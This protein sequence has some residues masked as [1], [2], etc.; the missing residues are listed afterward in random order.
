M[1]SPGAI[2]VGKLSD[3]D[4][5]QLQLAAAPGA[6]VGTTPDH[7]EVLSPAA[8]KKTSGPVDVG[9]MS[10]EQ[11]AQLQRQLGTAAGAPIGKLESFGRGTLEGATMG[12]EDKLGF[13][14][15]RREASKQANPWTHFMGEMTGATAPMAV[16]GPLAAVRGAGLAARGLR[17]LATPFAVGEAGTLGQGVVQGTK[18]ATSYGTLSGA[19]HADVKDT[20]TWSEAL[21]KRGIGAAKGLGTGLV[22]GPVVGAGGYGVSRLV[23]AALNRT[24]PELQDVM[25][26]ASAPELQGIRDIVR[27]AGYDKY[28]MADF[29][30]LRDRLR[31]PTQAHM[32]DGLNLIE[33][34]ETKP[35]QAMP[36]TGELKP[37]VT[38]SP[39]LGDMAQDFA[40]TGG[41]GRQKAVEAFATR[42]NEMSG[43]V[44]GDIDAIFGKDEA[45]GSA[46]ADEFGVPRNIPSKLADAEGLP[47]LIDQR[48][49]SGARAAEADAMEAQKTALGKRYDRLRAKPL[50]LIDENSPITR[51]AQTVPEFQKALQ[52]AAN[53]DMI[54]LSTLGR[55]V[56][57]DVGRPWGQAWIPGDI[58]KTVQTL[59]PNNM[60][61]IHHALAMSAK[62][63]VTGA[64]PESMMAG[65]LKTWFSN[66]VD[67]Q[68]KAHKELRGDYAVF[69]QSMEAQDHASKLPV[70][71]GANTPA[72]KFLE[73][74]TQDYRAALQSVQKQTGTYDQAMERF[75]AGQRKT[76][77][78]VTELKNRLAEVES[79]E[80]VLGAFRKAWGENIKQQLASGADPAK[81]VRSALTP[82]GQR[83]IIM[84]LGDKEGPAFI[85]DLLTIEA[86]NQG[87]SLGLNA[88]GSDHA[89]LQFFNRAMSNGNTEAVQAFKH[90]WG[91]R[92]KQELAAQTA[93]PNSV[94]TKLLTQQGK[95]RILQILG[96]ED[97]RTFI[98]SLYN[99]AQQMGLSQRLWGGPDTAYKLARNKKSD[100]LMDAVHGIFHLRPMQ[101]LKALG[102]LGSS[103]YKQ[104]RADQG[105]ALLAQQGPENVG[106]ILDAIIARNQLIRTGQPYVLNPA[107]RAVGPY[108]TT[109]PG[110]TDVSPWPQTPRPPYRP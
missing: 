85:K 17:A 102:E 24:M 66:W 4:F 45:L 57:P 61:D 31:D 60:L 8:D 65:K 25:A 41:A 51:V 69:K 88:G 80:D 7:A 90:A 15:E 100:A 12:F 91:E 77:P 73:Q 76:R 95:S 18:L 13:D 22:L 9:G 36:G 53:N 86:R 46:L 42:K 28:S 29:A 5:A 52:Y 21:G 30:A 108:T 27:Q 48:F 92:I 72:L 2:D 96:P 32:Y 1:I 10:D 78:S 44:Q 54:R 23:G 37:P 104:Q 70:T 97:G 34:L 62:P 105:N 20:D 55:D 64:T 58:G 26:A 67:Q 68:F 40:N 49:G 35:L 93:G 109:V 81:F 47:K 83:R 33:A 59:S 84:A 79:R 63:P 94:I 39:N 98:E 3:D 107:L 101:A 75:Q 16:A 19:G 87:M 99:K 74:V 110:Q 50:Q 106:A 43:K 71:G 89:A 14:K 11:F 103:A 6:A 56:Q 82:E 38:V